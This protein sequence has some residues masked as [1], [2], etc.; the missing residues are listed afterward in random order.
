MTTRLVLLSGILITGDSLYGQSFAETWNRDGQDEAVPGTAGST[1]RELRNRSAGRPVSERFLEDYAHAS[2]EDG[3]GLDSLLS[4]SEYDSAEHPADFTNAPGFIRK[5]SFLNDPDSGD[6]SGLPNRAYDDTELST[7]FRDSSELL[8]AAPQARQAASPAQLFRNPAP[9]EDSWQILP[10]GLLYRTYLAG[11]KEPR[12]QYL[13]LYDTKNHRRV[14]DATLGGRVGLLRKGSGNPND[15]NGFQLD[16]DGA[17]FARVLPDEP[18][19]MLEGSDYRVGLAG[20]WRQDRL[21]WKFGYCHISSHIGDEFLLAYPTTVRKNYVRDSV[22]AG[23]SYDMLTA[24]RVYAEFGYALGVS[25][26]AEP[27]ELQLGTEWTPK[28]KTA[29]GAPF[30]A[31]NTQFREEQ[32]SNA[33]LN[34]GTGWGWEGSQTR[35]RVRVGANYYNGP[36]LQYSFAD[37]RENLVGG[38]I[39]LDF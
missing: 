35:H 28:A 34:V 5:T 26:G 11:P 30:A 7:A 4:D 23:I 10:T 21:A 27:F 12:L 19:T 13:S 33:G 6:D 22:I 14:A 36:S 39:W 24:S 8:N 25:G 38:G 32:G 31:F 17:V 3:G 9:Q 20:T 37:R 15:L 16:V 1:L 18:S 2:Q 29:R